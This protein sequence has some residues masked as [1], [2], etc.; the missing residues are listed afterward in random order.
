MVSLCGMGMQWYGGLLPGFEGGYWL[1][2]GCLEAKLVGMLKL[3]TV[4]WG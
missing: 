1:V 4:G 2:N 3:T